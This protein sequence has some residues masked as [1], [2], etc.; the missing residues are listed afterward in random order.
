M[1][2]AHE[3][4]QELQRAGEVMRKINPSTAQGLH[5]HLQKGKDAGHCSGVAPVNG[6]KKV[7]AN[8]RLLGVLFD[9]VDEG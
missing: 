5:Q 2:D 6:V 4:R 1:A 3:I 9:I 8:R 7:V